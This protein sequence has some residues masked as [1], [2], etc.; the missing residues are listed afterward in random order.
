[1][2][3]CRLPGVLGRAHGHVPV[4][5]A[6]SNQSERNLHAAA[7]Y[8]QRGWR[9]EQAGLVAQLNTAISLGR[10]PAG[11]CASVEPLSAAPCSVGLSPLEVKVVDW[12]A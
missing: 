10:V 3:S 1:M 5:V 12:E 4:T 8:V 2:S 9:E 11:C 6:F 7:L